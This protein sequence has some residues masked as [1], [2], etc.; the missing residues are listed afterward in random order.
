MNK[1]IESLKGVLIEDQSLLQ[2]L[3]IETGYIWDQA[4]LNDQGLNTIEGN[5]YAVKYDLENP[6]NTEV[7]FIEGFEGVYSL[8]AL[9]EK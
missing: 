6:N 5:K 7:Y 2:K 9:Q 4:T 8:T 3:N 1:D